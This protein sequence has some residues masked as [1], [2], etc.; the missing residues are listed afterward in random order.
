MIMQT[1]HALSFCKCGDNVFDRKKLSNTEF[2]LRDVHADYV[3]QGSGAEKK[4][5]ISSH[6]K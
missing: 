4:G 6:I 3:S 2:Q 1:P 5:I